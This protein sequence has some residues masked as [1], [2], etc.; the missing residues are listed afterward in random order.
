MYGFYKAL[1]GLFHGITGCP[2]RSLHCPGQGPPNG[3][4]EEAMRVDLRA[5][6]TEG[7]LVRIADLSRA[8]PLLLAFLRH[9]G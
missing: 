3:R 4:L 8:R 2:A 1:T 9:F 7:N 6:D 5:L